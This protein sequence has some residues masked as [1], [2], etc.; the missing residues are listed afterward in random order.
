MR[1]AL[2]FLQHA[3]RLQ[4]GRL[5]LATF[6]LVRAHSWHVSGGARPLSAPA[7]PSP[8]TARRRY[9]IDAEGCA[10][11]STINKWENGGIGGG[12]PPGAKSRG[13]DAS[14]VATFYL[15]VGDLPSKP[16]VLHRWHAPHSLSAQQRDDIARIICMHM[17]RGSACCGVSKTVGSAIAPEAGAIL[18]EVGLGEG[19]FRLT[20]DDPCPQRSKTKNSP[21]RSSH[22]QVIKP[23]CT[24][25]LSTSSQRGR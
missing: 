23:R 1:S 16:T 10:G 5:H 20:A 25:S 18:E 2:P 21:S 24:L 8:S 6:L 15:S 7:S 13:E 4:G 22:K 11:K 14:H 9:G 19:G 3:L 17:A 12:L